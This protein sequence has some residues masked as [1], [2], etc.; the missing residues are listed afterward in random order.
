MPVAPVATVRRQRL[1]TFQLPGE[2][3]LKTAMAAAA[4]AAAPH[5]SRWL[6]R[7]HHNEAGEHPS[8]AATQTGHGHAHEPELLNNAIMGVFTHDDAGR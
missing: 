2:C 4:A 6:Q 8:S 3:E 5:G 1:D 7:Q